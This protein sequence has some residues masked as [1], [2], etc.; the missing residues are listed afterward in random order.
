MQGLSAALRLLKP[1]GRLVVISFHSLEDRIVK[2][3]IAERA[4]EVYDR[5]NPFRASQNH[6]AE[7]T[8]TQ[9]ALRPRNCGQPA[10]AQRRHAGGATPACTA[11]AASA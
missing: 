9:Q 11:Q 5:R 7:V 8:G 2:R 3:F 4:R 10:C 1:G 6:G